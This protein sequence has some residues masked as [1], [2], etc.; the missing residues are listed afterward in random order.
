[1]PLESPVNKH[2]KLY[3]YINGQQTLIFKNFN[4][5]QDSLFFDSTNQVY[6][7]AYKNIKIL[8]PEFKS[9]V[10]YPYW[11]GNSYNNYDF[12]LINT[13]IYYAYDIDPLTGLATNPEAIYT[14]KNTPMVDTIRST[15]TNVFLSATLYDPL[16]VSKFLSNLYSQTVFIDSISQMMFNKKADGLL[17][18]LYPVP[19]KHHA[20]YL[21]FI[22][23]LSQKIKQLQP[24]SKLGLTVSVKDIGLLN[25]QN[26]LPIVDLFVAS[27]YTNGKNN[28]NR[29]ISAPFPLRSSFEGEESMENIVDGLLNEGVPPQKIL[30]TVYDFSTVWE[31]T[32]SKR[33]LGTFV[34][35]APFE[36]ILYNFPN[37]EKISVYDSAAACNYLIS[38]NNLY[39][40]ENEKS[41]LDK[42]IW[43]QSKG[44]G[45]ITFW[46]IVGQQSHLPFWNA[47]EKG[48][49]VDS[50]A[51]ITPSLSKDRFPY[52][53]SKRLLKYQPIIISGLLILFVF[54]IAGVFIALLDWRVREIFFEKD[55][56]KFFYTLVL[57]ASIT[58]F[59]YLNPS[60]PT[61]N[62]F[63]FI[64]GLIL[65]S[66]AVFL[67]AHVSKTNKNNLP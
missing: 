35:Y 4:P 56:F 33:Q 13:F 59:F 64:G 55:L 31:L 10:W 51:S 32:H 36:S 18:D 39:W 47:I 3:K 24:T 43:L 29:K 26:T 23:N 12:D 65:G 34:D 8:H 62:L 2:S 27:N 53:V 6:Y 25:F 11:N 19:E 37:R 48:M 5:K 46:T 67:I 21:A 42:M 1:M 14:W 17:L 45:G 54:C 63:L 38:D 52:K 30:M 40:Y 20:E 58:L 15:R 7:K 41:L 50:I 22:Q 66:L 60:F 9:V 61:N 57:L 44:I 16:P 28:P 49:T